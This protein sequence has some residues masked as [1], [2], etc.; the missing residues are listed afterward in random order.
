[1]SGGR[2]LWELA[3]MKDHLL[4]LEADGVEDKD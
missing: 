2:I 3:E 1:M 4:N